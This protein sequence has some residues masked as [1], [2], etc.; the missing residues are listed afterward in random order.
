LSISLSLKS[1]DLRSV[2]IMDVFVNVGKARFIHSVDKF[3]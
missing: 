3:T 2:S 1:F